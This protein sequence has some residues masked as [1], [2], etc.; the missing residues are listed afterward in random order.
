MIDKSKVHNILFITL[1]NIGDVVLTLPVLGVLEKEFPEAKITVMVSAQAKEI[2][3]NDPAITKIIAYDKHVGFLKKVNL[4]LRLRRKFFDLVV[5]LRSTIYPA[6]I[7]APYKTSL[8]SKKAKEVIHK[9]Y[10]HLNKLLPLGLDIK[11][12]SYNLFFNDEDKLK[13]K[14]IFTELNISD[15]DKLVAVAPGAKSHIKRW[16]ASGF[17]KVC[18][19]LNKELGVKVL[20]VGDSNDKEITS[21]I[22]ASGL[23]NTYDISGYTNIRELAYL[24][25]QCKLLITNDSSPMHLADI[26]NTPAIAIFGPTDYKKY[27]PT[28]KN[29]Q[30]IREQLK[31]S[32]C[33]RAQCGYNLE[34]MKQIG[35]DEV[36]EA[37]KR[38]LSHGL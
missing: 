8:I 1:S 3:Q 10:F 20:L 7:N 9:K 26:V 19:R 5:D 13:V 32:P 21:Q 38:I 15:V 37:A 18:Q 31:C 6:L 36:F 11:G 27:G 34:C 14:T 29:S 2:F 23:N 17:A 30:V 33:K 28:L 24:L 16:T 4:G 22:I 35:A 12:A 25:S